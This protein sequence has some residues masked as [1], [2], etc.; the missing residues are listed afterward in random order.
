VK[1]AA[2]A[3]AARISMKEGLNFSDEKTIPGHSS[4][5]S[6]FQPWLV[7]LSTE[8]CVEHLCYDIQSNEPILLLLTITI[9]NQQR[10]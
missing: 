2:E 7:I 4:S 1:I 6:S 3:G 5:V 8:S 9:S 10:S